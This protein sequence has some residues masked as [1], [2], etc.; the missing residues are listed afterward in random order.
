[1]HNTGCQDIKEED[2]RARWSYHSFGPGVEAVKVKC[3]CENNTVT[4]S[5]G[6]VRGAAPAAGD[7]LH[8][9]QLSVV[10]QSSLAFQRV[11]PSC[12]LRTVLLLLSLLLLSGLTLS[13]IAV[14]YRYRP[15]KRRN[16]I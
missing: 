8:S 10:V 13:S 14:L 11:R 6:R 16:R 7:E 15:N 9:T 5:S 12:V 4:S 1:V 3:C 2:V